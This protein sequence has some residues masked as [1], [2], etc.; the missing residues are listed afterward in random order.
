V[1]SQVRRYLQSLASSL[2]DSSWRW[3]PGVLAGLLTILLLQLGAWQQFEQIAYRQLFRLRGTRAL[4]AKIAIVAIDDASV[5]KLGAFPW[6][7]QHY[8]ALW[9]KL[10]GAR[11]VGWTFPLADRGIAE[12][13]EGLNFTGVPIV[14]ADSWDSQPLVSRSTSRADGMVHLDGT[15][16]L[17]GLIRTLPMTRNRRPAFSLAVTEAAKYPAYLPAG[18]ELWLNWSTAAEQMPTYSAQAV[19]AENF[20]RRLLADKIVLVGI[21]TQNIDRLG[22]PFDRFNSANGVHLQ[23]TAIDNLLNGRGLYPSNKPLLIF[24][25]LFLTPLLSWRLSQARPSRRLLLLLILSGAWVV[26]AIVALHFNYLLWVAVPLA[27]MAAT[28]VAVTF[29]ERLYVDYLLDRQISDLWQ[30]HRIA[31][32]ASGHVFSAIGAEPSDLVTPQL[33][34][35]QVSRLASL[36]AEFGRAQSAQAAITHSLSMGLLATE[37]DGRIWFCNSVAANLLQTNVERQVEQC[38]I[39]DWLSDLEWQQALVQLRQGVFI[40][41]KEVQRVDRFFNLKLEPLIEWQALQSEGHDRPMERS[42]IGVLIA[43]EDITAAKQLQ[44]LVLEIEIQRRQELTK[45]NI[46]LEKARQIAEAAA[47]VKSAFLANMSHEIRTPMNGVVGLTNLLLETPLNPEQE[48]FV[49]TIK[50]SADHLLKIINEILDFS[51]LESGEMQAESIQ[52]NLNDQVEQAI[53]ILANRAHHKNLHLSYWIAPRTPVLVV[54]D[55]TRLN[56]ILT[57]LIGNAIK[58]TEQ[59]GVTIDVTPVINDDQTARVRFV[60][61][62]TGIGIAPENQHKLFQSFSQA[63]AS[64]TRQYGGTG[65]G[66]AICQK[67]VDLMGGKIGVDSRLDSGSSFWFELDFPTLA[68]PIELPLPALKGVSLLIVDR[69]A[70][71][72]QTL[73]RITS[74]WG[75]VADGLGN[76]ED[77]SRATRPQLALIDWDM[78]NTHSLVEDLLT[79]AVPIIVMTTFD[80]YESAHAKLGDRVHYLFK[81]LKSG[82]L[83]N[84]C[85]ELVAPSHQ[86]PAVSPTAQVAV[87]VKRIDVDILLAED[88]QVNQKVALRQLHKLGYRVDVV[89][90]GREVLEQLAQKSY[91]VILMDCHMPVLDGYAAAA[92]IRQLPDRRRDIAIIALTASVMQSDLEQALA[93]GMNDFLSKPVKIEQL[94]QAIERWLSQRTLAAT[95]PLEIDRPAN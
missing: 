23:A 72:M 86:L 92:A 55:P 25:L 36:A 29:S 37:L 21:A 45:Q 64:T 1:K 73:V 47:S 9:D 17:D 95:A 49:S 32:I 46:A 93:V 53:E 48:D 74:Q 50:V 52:F 71:R 56:Q 6:P 10:Q 2:W 68:V 26:I 75:M 51:K 79:M 35:A 91:D 63:D 33:P 18:G 31:P 20:D 94:Q 44:S 24:L 85:T 57:N 19:L 58:F 70:H 15:E 80:R 8:Q 13:M 38:L 12:G 90:N 27:A 7:R 3:T 5:E 81:P 69:W 82:R 41:P 28:G 16:D 84:L 89:N 40:T 66:L 65:L 11:A 78:G 77:F 42:I 59:G 87:P 30:A 4:D 39:P 43:I 76:P 34:F 62:D 67:L 22:T 61:S 54:G 14:L 60:V 83:I 88:N